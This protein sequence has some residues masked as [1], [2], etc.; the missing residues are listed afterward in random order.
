MLIGESFF[1][2]DESEYICPVCG[3]SL[4]KKDISSDRSKILNFEDGDSAIIEDF[5]IAH[6][7][8][9]I[10]FILI[11]GSRSITLQ[12]DDSEF[13]ISEWIGDRYGIMI[14]S[15][16]KEKY[17]DLMRKISMKHIDKLDYINDIIIDYLPNLKTMFAICLDLENLSFLAF[18]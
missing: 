18:K 16:D 6:T 2:T 7:H 11:I 17:L 1:I 3:V 9:D 12:K 5:E 14:K 10:N 13:H 4:S 8:Q 15:K